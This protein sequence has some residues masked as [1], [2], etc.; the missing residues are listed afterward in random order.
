MSK[1]VRE[2]FPCRA[3]NNKRGAGPSPLTC[4]H[5]A[6]TLRGYL[7][8]QTPMRGD[9]RSKRRR[10]SAVKSRTEKIELRPRSSHCPMLLRCAHGVTQT[11][12]PQQ[13][14]PQVKSVVT[15]TDLSLSLPTKLAAGFGL[16]DVRSARSR[17]IHPKVG[18][19]VF[20][21]VPKI[22]LTRTIRLFATNICCKIY[23]P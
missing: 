3:R 6:V 21:A 22:R 14:K 13:K 18:S 15:A 10:R 12:A 1:R 4:Q 23:I 17:R 16:K 11:R 9:N 8:T 2:I 19:S 7:P 5:R 20:R